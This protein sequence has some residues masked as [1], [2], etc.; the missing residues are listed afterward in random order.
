MKMYRGYEMRGGSGNWE[1]THGCCHGDGRTKEL[2]V[3]AC[4]KD[5]QT[6]K[7]MDEVSDREESEMLRDQGYREAGPEECDEDGKVLI[8]PDGTAWVLKDVSADCPI[9]LG[10]ESL[11]CACRSDSYAEMLEEEEDDE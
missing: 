3:A 11:D 5:R 8:G 4:R 2:A 6:E 9:C 10:D 1:A 7:E